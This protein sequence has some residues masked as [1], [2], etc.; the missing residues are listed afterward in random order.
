MIQALGFT[1]QADCVA[2]FNLAKVPVKGTVYQSIYEKIKKLGRSSGLGKLH[3]HMLR[4]TYG[5]CICCLFIAGCVDVLQ[6]AF[7]KFKWFQNCCRFINLRRSH[8]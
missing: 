1:G 8:Y 3:P 7:D 6:L 5:I 2:A 4:H